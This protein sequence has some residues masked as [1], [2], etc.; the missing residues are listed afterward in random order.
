[1]RLAIHALEEAGRGDLVEQVHHAVR[2]REMALEGR[3]DGEAREM[4][5][6][7]PSRVNLAEILMHA[8]D[9]WRKFGD[10]VNA[11][12]VGGVAE[13]L[14]AAEK[15]DGGREP[16]RESEVRREQEKRAAEAERE[17]AKRQLEI[18]R[19]A[20]AAFLEDG[21]EDSAELLEL[22]FRARELNLEGRRDEKA[23]VI[24]EK[25]PDHAQVTEL[26]LRGAALWDEFG[27]EDKAEKVRAL[28]EEMLE[29]F[30]RAERAERGER[31]EGGEDPDRRRDPE[32]VRVKRRAAV[33]VEMKVEV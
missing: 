24:R 7:A 27:H 17:V 11:R 19:L 26:L 33:E 18:L 29:Q 10:E 1:M 8:S 22:A 32:P 3:R 20:R 23:Q 4:Q 16:A 25:A 15:R 12:Q 14:L 2:S 30:E 5:A 28:G 21:R 9:L 13:E 31:G 6:A